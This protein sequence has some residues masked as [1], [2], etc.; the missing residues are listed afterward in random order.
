MRAL[1][2]SF[3]QQP[4]IANNLS[5]ALNFSVL[6]PLVSKDGEEVAGR[7]KTFIFCDGIYNFV[8][9]N[10][11]FVTILSDVRPVSPTDEGE[12]AS[13]L[14]SREK[15]KVPERKITM[16]NTELLFKLFDNIEKDSATPS[17]PAS[18]RP[19][20]FREHPPATGSVA[21]T[22]ASKPEFQREKHSVTLRRGR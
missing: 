4:N 16:A 11:N 5:P 9:F 2:Q 3:W 8:Q 13:R 6:P 22:S 1:P 20:H 10:L 21:M 18:T 12:K 17:K 14:K 7:V 19:T 15:P